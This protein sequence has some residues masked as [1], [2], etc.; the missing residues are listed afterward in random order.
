MRLA[1]DRAP[2]TSSACGA[3]PVTCGALCAAR[4]QFHMRCIVLVDLFGDELLHLQKLLALQNVFQLCDEAMTRWA[5]QVGCAALN[6]SSQASQ[7]IRNQKGK[8]CSS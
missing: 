5:V 1:E 2:T 4:C 3:V 8:S 6:S 7:S